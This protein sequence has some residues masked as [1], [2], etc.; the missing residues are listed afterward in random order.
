M[1]EVVERPAI[2][3]NAQIVF[4]TENTDIDGYKPEDFEIVGY[5][6]HDFVKLPVSV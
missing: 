2:S 6:S 5:K 1:K 3:D 4:H